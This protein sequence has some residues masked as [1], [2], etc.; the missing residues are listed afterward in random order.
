MTAQSVDMLVP[1]FSFV[2]LFQGFF[3]LI[4]SARVCDIWSKAARATP[5]ELLDT[6]FKHYHGEVIRYGS[7]FTW[8]CLVFKLFGW[9]W[10]PHRFFSL[11][12]SGNLEG[13]EFRIFQHLFCERF[14]LQLSSFSFDEYMEFQ[15]EK[16]ILNLIELSPL[17][18]MS[19]AFVL[20]IEWVRS[21]SFTFSHLIS[22]F[23]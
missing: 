4:Y 5:S 19:F 22:V 17:S 1:I 2:T 8:L 16:F 11:W 23:A 6:F 13:A 15:F 9:R 20:T 12:L 10:Q 14:Q 3:W 7:H 21:D 18:W